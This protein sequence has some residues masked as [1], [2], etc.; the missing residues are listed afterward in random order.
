[1]E[2]RHLRTSATSI[3]VLVASLIMYVSSLA[4]EVSEEEEENYMTYELCLILLP[5]PWRYNEVG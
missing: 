3:K 4:E 5:M 2:V 1:M